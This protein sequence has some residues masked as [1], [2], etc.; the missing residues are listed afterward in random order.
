MNTELNIYCQYSATR[1]LKYITRDIS[2]QSQLS[3]Q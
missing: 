2:I 3:T 1:T